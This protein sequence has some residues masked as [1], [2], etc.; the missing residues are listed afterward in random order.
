MTRIETPLAA[1]VTDKPADKT[2]GKAASGDGDNR[3]AAFRAL[4]KQLGGHDKVA[5]GAPDKETKTPTGDAK[6]GLPSI[7][8]RIAAKDDKT[9]DSTEAGTATEVS[10]PTTDNEPVLVWQTILGGGATDYPEPPVNMDFAFRVSAR[11]PDRETPATPPDKTQ[12]PAADRPERL[13]N[14][15][16]PSTAD[17]DPAKGGGSPSTEAAD[18]FA[19]LSSLL[20]KA[21]ENETEQE[22]ADVVP[23]R[24]SVVS[25]ETHFEPVAR[26]S[27][28]QQIAATVGNE[29]VATSEAAPTEAASQTTEPSRH[30]SGPL[31]VL[32]LKLEPE[33]LGAVVLKMRLVDKSLELEVIASRQE[34]ADL[35]AKDRDMLTR[36]LRSSGYSADIV[37]ISTSTLPSSGQ[38][39]NDNQAGAHGS[40]GHPGAQT[41]GDRGSNDPAGSGGR[42]PSRPQPME[43]ATHEESSAGRSGGDV[44]L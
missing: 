8:G 13:P 19:T 39:M 31:K 12:H 36:A 23:I 7:R 25:R 33:D 34:T 16:L 38:L 28:V 3:H 22:A 6:Q 43:G 26:L 1:P 30:T 20:N 32:H 4:L 21:T 27:P 5:A 44:Y 37:T 9:P 2:I 41:G 10:E 24:M 17:L 29:L 42:P 14:I 35:L 40:A 18:P 15:A 11:L